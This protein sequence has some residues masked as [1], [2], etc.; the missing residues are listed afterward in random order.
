MILDEIAAKT[1]LRLV[2]TKEKLPPELIREQ[3][4]AKAAAAG[5]GTG[6]PADLP[7]AQALVAPGLSFI[8]EVKKASPSK[9]LIAPDF[10][11]RQI[12]RDYEAAG[13]AAVS[14]LTEPEFFLGS[15][16]YLREIAAE[17]RIPLLRKD[18]IVDAYQIYQAKLL[19]ASAVLLICAL[20]DTE[21][22]AGHI[23]TAASL[24]MSALVE[25]HSEAEAE[26]A[27]KAG[28]GIIG[29]NNRDLKTFAVNLGLAALLRKLI[30]PGIVTVAESGIK[31]PADTRVLRDLGFDAV[32]VGESLMRAPDKKKFLAALR[33]G[34]EGERQQV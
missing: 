22:L 30:P 24:G 27:L 26:S 17:I 6:N 29:I 4:L 13:A 16:E 10:P 3:A 21:T 7:F 8:C 15:D 18:F 1:R 28:A 20:L 25:I 31:S 11:Y 32:L 5:P 19:G 14:V 33:N 23:K 34:A 12:A 9:G 2:E